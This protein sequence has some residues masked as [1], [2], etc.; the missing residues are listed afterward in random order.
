MDDLAIGGMASWALILVLVLV[1][2]PVPMTAMIP[3][4][5]LVATFEVVRVLHL[6]IERIGRYIQVFFEDAEAEPGTLT[7]PAW[8]RTAMAF[9]STVPGAGGHPLFVPLF[10][11][12][13]AVN[14]LAVILP[15]PILVESVTLAVPHLAFVA[16]MLHCDRGM[17]RQRQ[18]D[19][20][21]FRELKNMP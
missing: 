14:G 9:G 6:G 8:E 7:A 20:A 3:L 19:L 2:L 15:G 21:R 16:W 18:S 10:L 17:R 1:W 12:A 4:M 13:T 11:M 5:V